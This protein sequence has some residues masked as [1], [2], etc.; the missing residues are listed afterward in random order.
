MPKGSV[1]GP[2]LFLWYIN[3]L[4]NALKYCTSIHF[5]DDTSL[6]LKNKSLKQMQKYFNIDLKMLTTGLKQIKF[7]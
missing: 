7:L 2:L 4:N 5:A 6:L 1:L 3:D